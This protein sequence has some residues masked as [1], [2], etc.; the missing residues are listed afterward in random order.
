[1]SAA[2]HEHER[3]RSDG[4]LR[5]M[6]PDMAPLLAR[7]RAARR[8]RR[9][10][11]IDLGVGVALAILLLLIAPGLAIVALVA[12]VVILV[13]GVSLLVERRRGPRRDPLPRSRRRAVPRVAVRTA[14]PRAHASQVE[15]PRERGGGSL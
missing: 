6:R 15:L 3:E 14:P 9:L 8:R 13:C 4:D 2:S 7:R 12:S 5:R 10:A 1:M 11:R